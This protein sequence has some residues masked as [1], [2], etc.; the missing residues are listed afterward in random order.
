MRKKTTAGKERTRRQ[1]EQTIAA[2]QKLAEEDWLTGLY[3]GRAMDEKAGEYLKRNRAGSMILMDIDQFKKINDTYG[4]IIGDQL[5]QDIASVLKKMFPSGCLIGR[6]GGD[7]FAIFMPQT[8]EEEDIQRRCRQIRERFVR[9]EVNGTVIL[10]LSMTIC[11]GSYHPGFEYKD[12]FDLA[13]QKIV[14]EKR[15]RNGETLERVAV[16]DVNGDEIRIDMKILAKE[17]REED[18][19]PGAY[20]QDYETFKSI[21]RFVERKMIR[22]DMGAF[23]ILFTL[24]DMANEFPTLEQ[25]D[26]QLELLG[27]AIQNNL[28]MG[29][30]Y[31]QYSSCQFLVM[32]S[33]TTEENVE[34]IAGR[35]CQAFYKEN[36]MEDELILH[37]TYPLKPAGK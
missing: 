25:R 14:K 19:L 8:L 28:R 17:M 24:T 2:Y 15:S 12:L 18:P 20:C 27:Q 16:A 3:N 6:C 4:H 35:I 33:D 36:K 32:L 30:L 22:K 7:E 34:M 10:R 21:Y 37:H 5:L 23:L 13:D 1:L 29:D 9:V 26:Y 11:G 31:A